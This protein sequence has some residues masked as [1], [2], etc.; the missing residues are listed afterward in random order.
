MFIK[1]KH[2][3]KGFV[4]ISIFITI[5]V[6]ILILCGIGYFGFIQYKNYQT[7][8]ADQNK[9][10]QAKEKEAQLTAEEQQKAFEIAQQEIEKLKIQNDELNK[11]QQNL[12]QKVQNAQKP[13]PPDSTI[14]AAELDSYLTGVVNIVCGDLSGSGTLQI[15][16]NQ[17]FVLT[18]LHVLEDPS[19]SCQIIVNAQDNKPIGMYLSDP[20]KSVNWNDL[21]DIIA[22]KIGSKK[23]IINGG[24]NYTEKSKNINDLNYKISNLPN[25]PTNTPVGAP[26]VIIGFPAYGIIK[27]TLD[28]YPIQESV[29]V[30]SNGII[31]GYDSI[32][33][34]TQK[35]PYS[36]YFVSAKIDSGNSGGIAL[37]KNEKGLCVLGVPTWLTVGNYETQG[38]VQNIHNI[39]YKQ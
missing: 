34:D 18:N 4:R 14:S 24:V 35:L 11:T 2:N 6:S 25:C 36:N 32:V 30:V 38:L 23:P 20:L 17:Y 31:S 5:I 13:Q 7:K 37:S 22:L 9:L 19:E 39:Y 10:T 27:S 16:S 33:K 1:I 15:Y 21:T 12:E 26:V 8:M 3:S 29:R 28:G